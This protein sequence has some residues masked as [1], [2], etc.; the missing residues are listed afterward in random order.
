MHTHVHTKN[1]LWGPT[2]QCQV[3]GCCEN[4]HTPAL[5]SDNQQ[6]NWPLFKDILYMTRAPQDNYI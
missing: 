2:F 4:I 3:F 6:I 1:M 5:L